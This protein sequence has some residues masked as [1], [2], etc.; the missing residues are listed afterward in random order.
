MKKT[1]IDDA[2]STEADFLGEIINNGEKSVKCRQ[3]IVDRVRELWEL[4]GAWTNRQQVGLVA[5]LLW[6]SGPLGRKLQSDPSAWDHLAVIPPDVLSD[7]QL[8]V[9]AVT[10]NLPA[11]IDYPGEPIDAIMVTDASQW[12]WGAIWL[13]ATGESLQLAQ[14]PWGSTLRGADRSTV[15]EPEAVWRALCR[16][17]RPCDSVRVCILSDHQ[18]FVA[19]INRGHSAAAGNNGV[20]ARIADR[21]PRIS[22]R[23]VFIPGATNPADELSRQRAT[24]NALDRARRGVWDVLGATHR[25]P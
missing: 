14:M 19:A 22:L 16:F 10:D 24:A 9:D 8:W 20:L 25:L 3:K 2:V 4:R 18:P 17:F 13:N 7:L 5:I 21:F 15:A 11:H 6:C 12:G 23:A 1:E